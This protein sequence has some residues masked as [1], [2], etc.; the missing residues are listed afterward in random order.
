MRYL[1]LFI[2]FMLTMQSVLAAESQKPSAPADDEKVDVD[3]IKEK[4]WARGEQSQM[5]VVQNRLYSKEKKFQLALLGGVSFSDPFLTIQQ[6][7]FSFGYHF[8]EYISLHAMGWRHF[9]QDSSAGAFFRNELGGVPPTNIP[10]YFLGGEL[11]ASLLY[12]KLSLVG[13]AIIYYD[14]HLLAGGGVTQTESG[15]YPTISV[16]IGQQVYLN[17]WF[18]ISVDYRFQW[19]REGV[20]K[21]SGISGLG[22]IEGYRDNWGHTINLGTNALWGF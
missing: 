19:Y 21:K 22:Q 8:N 17:K 4:Y 11:A 2:I 5:G 16:G 9:T 3:G 1:G 20:I 18:S 14:M 7:G 10:E 15:M 12:G 13:K 6:L